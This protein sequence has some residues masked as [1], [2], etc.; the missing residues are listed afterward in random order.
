MPEQPRISPAAESLYLEQERRR[1][2]GA[3]DQLDTGLEDT[4]PASDP[5]S[6]THSSVTTGRADAERAEAVAKNIQE[7][8]YPLVDDA[9]RHTGERDFSQPARRSRDE[10][11][12]RRHGTASIVGSVSEPTSGTTAATKSRAPS[13]RAIIENQIRQQP[14]ATVAVAAA[15]AFVLGATR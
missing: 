9:L 6:M 11:Q 15:L 1:R 10:V 8:D 3:N 14:I 7:E 2:R 5:V 13:F 4:F 12:A